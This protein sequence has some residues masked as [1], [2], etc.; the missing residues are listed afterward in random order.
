MS[1]YN[2]NNIFNSAL[3]YL[4]FSFL[5]ILFFLPKVGFAS[6]VSLTPDSGTFSVGNTFTVSVLLDTKGKSV[7][8]LQ[9]FL[10]F[11]PDKLQVVSPSTGSS[12]VDVWTVPPRYNNVTGTVDL[13]GGIPGGIIVSR[14]VLTTITFRVKSV[15]PAL[16]KFFSGSR[17]FLNDGLATEDLSQT[18]NALYQLK[19][20]PP[21]GPI[22]TSETHPDQSVWYSNND[23]VLRFA[24]G[25]A[26]VESFS[27][28]LNDDPISIPDNI[29]EGSRTSVSYTD[30]SEGIHYFHIKALRD[31][32][33]GGT[34]HFAIKV[35]TTPPA[36]FPLEILPSKRTT[37]TKPVIQFATTDADSGIDHYE[38]KIEPL[39]ADAV[40]KY[41]NDT[42]F[43]IETKGPF[44]PANLALGSYDVYVRAYDKANNFRE[45]KERMVITT[46][47][48]KFIGEK[49]IVF[50][51][52]FV[53]P[54]ILVWFISLLLLLV[55]VYLAYKVWN[56][57]H[58]IHKIQKDKKLPDDVKQQLDELKE[59]RKKYGL[60]A[61]AVFLFIIVPF[62]FHN[63]VRAETIE[64]SPPIIST[65]SKDISNKDIFYAGGRADSKDESIILYLQ[66]QSTGETISENITP[67]K[68]GEWFYRHNTFLSPG[69]YVLWTQGK[70]GEVFS[71]PSAQNQ[72]SVN[73][74]ALAFGANRLNYETIYL[75]FVMVLLFGVI[76]LCIFILYHTYHGR[77][78]HKEFKEEIKK[79][80]ESIRIG[81]AVLQRDIGAEL[82]ILHKLKSTEGLSNEEKDKEL[83]LLKDL[84]DVSRRIGRE[85]EY[86]KIEEEKED[87]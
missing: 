11:P 48:F 41:S 20:P 13:E 52:L 78:K 23:T 12:I 87:Q 47:L 46:P 54:W 50:N 36:D 58:I 42:S 24:N 2:I 73:R 60:K 69:D 30:L 61:L 25:T 67:D 33:W 10:A 74:T 76:G 43:F 15:G 14:G 49:G 83:E 81:F 62:N 44:L 4:F 85:L 8:A 80:E 40:L 9:V 21:E 26:S 34:T 27:Y 53:I 1:S 28:M 75:F 86:I 3:R 63:I 6:T 51:D 19:L 65:V 77:R 22:V 18:I 31:G 68:N 17:I 35:D 56:W 29:G 66:N 57:Y 7:N 84:D 37:S 5:F 70:Y 79:V 45:I 32:I 16:V 64:L 71:P 38:L 55:L 82:A 39:S 72:L 59:Y